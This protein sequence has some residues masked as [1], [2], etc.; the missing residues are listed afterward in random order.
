ME[1]KHKNLE[2]GI[3]NKN[4]IIELLGPP[5]TKSTF[6]NDLWIY[7]EISNSSSKISKLGKRTLIANNI[8]ILDID[9]KGLLSKSIFLNKDDM[10]ILEF[11]KDTTEINYSRNQFI[12][13]FLNSMRQK[14]NDP[15]GKKKIK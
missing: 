10:N 5:S 8:L 1:K 9:R 12:Y 3:S 2:V 13:E 6:E 7:I 11:S 15:L 4:D 14:I